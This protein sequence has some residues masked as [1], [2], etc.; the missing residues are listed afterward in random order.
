MLSRLPL[1]RCLS[2]VALLFY[3]L[4]ASAALIFHLTHFF[5]E[6]EFLSE[7]TASFLACLS[8]HFDRVSLRSLSPR[9]LVVDHCSSFVPS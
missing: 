5:Q 8:T 2:L 6:L 1:G 4:V 9:V 3:F 7:T